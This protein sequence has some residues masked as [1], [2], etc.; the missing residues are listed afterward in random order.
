[1]KRRELLLGPG[2]AII[3]MA[4]STEIAGVM[5][6]SP[7]SRGAAPRGRLRPVVGAQDQQGVFDRDDQDQRPEHQRHHAKHRLGLHC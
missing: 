4:D 2:C 1:M 3:P 6:P 5:A 7:Q